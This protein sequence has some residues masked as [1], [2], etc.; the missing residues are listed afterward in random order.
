M[1]AKTFPHIVDVACILRRVIGDIEI[2]VLRLLNLLIFKEVIVDTLRCGQEVLRLGQ[3]KKI[4]SVY[5]S[6]T[7]IERF[8]C[9]AKLK[10]RVVL[11]SHEWRA[12][13]G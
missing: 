5:I 7:Y 13:Q 9:A 11:I 12:V 8:D 6:L 4:K 2:L 1:F 10:F 3:L